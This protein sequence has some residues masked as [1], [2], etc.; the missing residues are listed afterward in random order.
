ML[1]NRLACRKGRGD[2]GARLGDVVP[3]ASDWLRVNAAVML[4]A[5]DDEVD[6]IAE[7]VLRHA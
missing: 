2:A 7:S 5:P 1:G 4:V 6:L 3:L